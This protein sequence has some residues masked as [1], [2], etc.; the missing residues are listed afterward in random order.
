MTFPLYVRASLQDYTHIQSY[1][2][3]T[4]DINSSCDC[5]ELTW[6]SPDQDSTAVNAGNIFAGTTTAVTKTLAP[7][8][9]NR[10]NLDNAC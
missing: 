7:P 5:N 8:V 3:I 1:K 10:N 9:T 4:I 2:L 6:E